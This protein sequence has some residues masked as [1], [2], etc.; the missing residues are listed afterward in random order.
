MP[1]NERVNH[2][3]RAWLERVK[4]LTKQITH[5][6]LTDADT[7]QQ[8]DFDSALPDGAFVIGAYAEVTT[9]MSGGSVSA[10]N[11]DLGIKSGDTDG[12]LDA[13]DIFTGAPS[14]ASVPRGVAVPGYH[15][16]S[17]PTIIVDSTGDNLVNLTAGD[18]T[19]VVLYIDETLVV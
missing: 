5:A 18:V 16:G 14:K 19:F 9:A 10:C 15:G 17:T 12:L 3:E 1:F 2:G 13:I 4:K 8:I 11:A 7:Q 6:D